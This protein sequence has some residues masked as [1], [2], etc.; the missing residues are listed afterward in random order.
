[1]IISHKYRFIFVKTAKTA[2][3]SLE[4]FLGRHCGEDDIITTTYP[5]VEG[6]RPRNYRRSFWPF[7]ELLSF[8]YPRD[9][10]VFC[11]RR[12]FTPVRTFKDC[13]KR[14]RY[15]EHIPARILKQRVDPEIWHSYH[16]F[17]FDRNPWEK[18][19]SHYNMQSQVR[20]GTMTLDQY[21]ERGDF[22]I[23]FPYY[24]DEAGRLMVDQVI[25]YESMEEDFGL[26]CQRLGIPWSGTLGVNAKSEYRS[27]HRPYTEVLTTAQADLIT[28]VF[29]REIEMHGYRYGE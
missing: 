11:E 2:G 6:H 8:N 17:A 16:K 4:V 29:Q 10:S 7:P 3:T 24:T 14:R 19:L 20:G 21:F 5:L 26:L 23:N 27:D 25:K 18:T 15:H 28:W 13:Y 9:K 22:C 1:M 12:F